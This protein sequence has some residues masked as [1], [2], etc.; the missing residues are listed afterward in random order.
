[1]NGSSVTGNCVAHARGGELRLSRCKTSMT[2][3]TFGQHLDVQLVQ[4]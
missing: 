1:M 3:R 2:G 4:L